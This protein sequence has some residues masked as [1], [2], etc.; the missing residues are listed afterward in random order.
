MKQL[1]YP[2]AEAEEWQHFSKIRN[3]GQTQPQIVFG[4]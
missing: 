1:V 3:H 4:S 2:G